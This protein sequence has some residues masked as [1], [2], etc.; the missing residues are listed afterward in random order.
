MVQIVFMCFV[1]SPGIILVRVLRQVF[2]RVPSQ[3]RGCS[4]KCFSARCA[5]V[6]VIEGFNGPVLVFIRLSDEC[7]RPEAKD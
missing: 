1:C 5:R 3:R 7:N 4:L 6:L 2:N